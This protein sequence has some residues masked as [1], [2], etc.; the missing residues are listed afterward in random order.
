M[1]KCNNAK[2]PN[3]AVRLN[4]AVLKRAT[5]WFVASEPWSARRCL[6][7]ILC[8]ANFWWSLGEFIVDGAKLTKFAQALAH[9]YV[10]S[11]QLKVLWLATDFSIAPGHW[12]VHTEDRITNYIN[13]VPWV[14]YSLSL[15]SCMLSVTLQRIRQ[16]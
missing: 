12:N 8:G 11:C 5:Q 13:L 7:Y 2:L 16:F 9:Y 1:L 15:F 14:I 10:Y 6:N 4:D 3:N